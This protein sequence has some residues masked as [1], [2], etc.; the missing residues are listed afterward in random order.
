LGI[1][2]ERIFIASVV[3]LLNTNSDFVV[4]VVVAVFV[5]KKELGLQ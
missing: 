3:V 2:S 4:V 5:S 1:H